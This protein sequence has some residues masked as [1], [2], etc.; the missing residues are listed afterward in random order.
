[1]EKIH[2]QWKEN[3]MS[4]E[5]KE[6]WLPKV[7]AR[8]GK[9]GREGESRLLDELCEDYGYERKYAIKM[10]GGMRP[11]A[12]G[13]S[14]PGPER[15]YGAIEP[16]VRQMWLAAEQPCG[17]RLVPI[18]RQ[19]LPSYE[20]RFG[21]LSQ[22]QRQLLRKISSATLD[23]LLVSAR[24]E[25]PGRGRCGTKPGSLLKTQIPIRTG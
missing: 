10:L 25:Y 21:K 24:A 12:R 11:V 3:N 19:W 23:R 6:Q 13:R 14:H 15:R 8:Y 1:M 17:K 9:R 5:L 20:R 18:L 4:L 7:Q 16:I 22:R 2:R